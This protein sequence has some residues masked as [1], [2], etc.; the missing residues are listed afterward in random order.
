MARTSTSTTKKRA[1]SSSARRDG[2]KAAAIAK[3]RPAKGKALTYNE[4]VLTAVY[5]LSRNKGRKEPVV[6]NGAV[7]LSVKA[8]A[9]ARPTTH[10]LPAKHWITKSKKHLI[11]IGALEARKSG[12]KLGLG[13]RSEMD[14]ER[15]GTGSENDSSDD[16]RAAIAFLA[17]Y[18]P[19]PPSSPTPPPASSQSS[20][21]HP[22]KKL[23]RP[24][25]TP[26]PRRKRPPPPTS[27][28]SSSD[29]D[30]D[31]ENDDEASS[32]KKKASRRKGKKWR[33][34]MK[35][36][37][38]R[39]AKKA[40]VS[41]EAVPKNKGKATKGKGKAKAL[42]SSEDGD[43]SD[44]SLTSLSSTS[45]SGSATPILIPETFAM[46]S[47]AKLYALLSAQL[48]AMQSERDKLENDNGVLSRGFLELKKRARDGGIEL[49]ESDDERGGEEEGEAGKGEE[50][51]DVDSDGVVYRFAPEGEYMGGEDGF[52]DGGEQWEYG[53]GSESGGA[54]DNGNRTTSPGGGQGPDDDLQDDVARFLA[55]PAPS[56]S[57]VD[58]GSHV[59]AKEDRTPPL[60][61]AN[62]ADDE[63]A[64][65]SPTNANADTSSSTGARTLARLPTPGTSSPLKPEFE[66]LSRMG[67]EEGADSD[68]N[69]DSEAEEGDTDSESVVGRRLGVGGSGLNGSL[70]LP[71]VATTPSNTTAL[72]ASITSLTSQLTST[73]TE[74]TALTSTHATT[75][76]SLES[77]T[78]EL[79]KA[80]QALT[81]TAAK[82]AATEIALT[83]TRKNAESQAESDRRALKRVEERMGGMA[84]VPRSGKE[85]QVV[86]VMSEKEV[87][88]GVKMKDVWV[89][90]EKEEDPVRLMSVKLEEKGK[91]LVEVRR[92]L[93]EKAEEVV[94]L[95][96]VVKAR[97]DDIIAL[98]T[99]GAAALE[100]EKHAH[101]ATQAALADATTKITSLDI[102]LQASH[103]TLVQLGTALDR[104]AAVA[105]VESSTSIETKKEVVERVTARIQELI[106]ES[107]DEKKR[108]RGKMSALSDVLRRGLD[109]LGVLEGGSVGVDADESIEEV[110]RN[111]VDA[112]LRT[113]DGKVKDLEEL[114]IIFR[115]GRKKAKECWGTLLGAR[116]FSAEEV[117]SL[118]EGGEEEVAKRL[119]KVFS[120]M[121]GGLQVSVSD[122]DEEIEGLKREMEG[123]KN[124][125]ARL[126]TELGM[127]QSNSKKLGEE[128]TRSKSIGQEWVAKMGELVKQGSAAWG[129]KE[130]KEGA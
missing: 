130:D 47:P 98:K 68:A 123:L 106:R 41:F 40:K 102:D 3:P 116:G 86:P 122:R 20:P 18:T 91:E 45:T 1:P 88:R 128:L 29:E 36:G 65:S 32:K 61:D 10:S 109:K 121:V 19:R 89:E 8:H 63:Q 30:A 112:L 69:A 62:D 95:E 110:V 82:L 37:E 70:K 77:T 39:V 100:Q 22:T 90:V 96:E 84:V 4:R 6:G 34:R 80:K 14:D 48:A 33:G 9:Q 55:S 51:R 49:P 43:D 46:L 5:S 103:A 67:R 66:E 101:F 117:E 21:P 50:E 124:E 119:V 60:P 81:A 120:E 57:N 31:S 12:V 104:L 83:T 16:E 38:K 79:E 7:N 97:Q 108:F 13:V 52:N 94:K 118:V 129:E 27:S 54:Q 92:E 105:G 71:D 64:P 58:F 93:A 75:V 59:P 85:V 11:D 35:G 17:T 111:Q 99:E 73:K 127:T 53:G 72:Q 113:L 26:K 126:G 28:G 114:E 24:K 56:H 74:L 42:A 2:P 125:L 115:E 25:A 44:S 76:G 107:E 87:G 23:P 78:A 15:G